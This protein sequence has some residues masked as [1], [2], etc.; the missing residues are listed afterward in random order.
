MAK[1]LSM[2]VVVVAI[3]GVWLLLGSHRQSSSAASQTGAEVGRDTVT[4]GPA[5]DGPRLEILEMTHSFGNVSQN[6]S[7][8]HTFKVRN[9]GNAPLEL[10]KAAAS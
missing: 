4:Q 8:S 7:V 5:V 1:K 9:A 3:A 2:L 10:I 6:A